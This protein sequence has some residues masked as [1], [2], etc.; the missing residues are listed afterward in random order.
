MMRL[1]KGIFLVIFV[2]AMTQSCTDLDERFYDQ[3]TGDNFPTTD[4]EFAATLGGAYTPMHRTFGHNNYFSIQEVSSDEAMIPQRG[5]DWFDGGQWL[6]V[7]RHEYNSREEVVNN[8]W[9]MAFEGVNACNR[10]IAVFEPLEGTEAI[11]AE[12]KVMR[13]FYYFWL[14]DVYGNVPIVTALGEPDPNG[15]SPRSAVYNFVTS[16]LA[17]N[18]PLL[19]EEKT[20]GR[21]NYWAGRALQAKVELNS[22]V[23]LGTGD[24]TS[25]AMA[26]VITYTSDIIDN[27]GFTLDSDYSAVFGAANDANGEHIFAI[28]YDE[29]F[30]TGFNLNQMTLHYGSQNT[31]NLAAQPWNGY[32]SLQEFYNSYDDADVRKA[33][34]FVAGPQFFADGVTPV[35]DPS[36]ESNDP[37]GPQLN[38]TPEINEHFP[39][40]LRQAGV[41]I[42]KYEIEM[43]AQPDKNND[44][45]IFRLG[46]VILMQA[47]AEFREG[48][49]AAAVT[50]VDQIRDRAGLGPL[51]GA[52]TAD[53]LLAERGREMFAEAYR[54]QDLI[55]FGRYND[56]WDFKPADASDHV[57]IYPI[58]DAQLNADPNLSQNPGYN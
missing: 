9:T 11:V 16:E 25:A 48:N 1:I 24:P 30:I 43:G 26:N 44:V 34:N 58:P 40:A 55:R 42:G 31:Y 10:L 8:V 50:L 38:F 41:R 52:L 29:V 15:Q 39:N 33:N 27:G 2:A 32:C 5:G 4:E 18:V 36:F 57:N 53:E 21:M 19:T 7:H 45:P 20:Y 47:E 22:G 12:M 3:I 28:P 49:N 46:D 54:R 37:D 17:A 13:A 35:D 6:R 56:A 51:G 14:M 23:Y